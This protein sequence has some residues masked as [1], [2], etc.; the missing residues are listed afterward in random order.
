MMQLVSNIVTQALSGILEIKDRISVFSIWIPLSFLFVGLSLSHED[1][2]LA[3][4]F[5][6]NSTES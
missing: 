3:V 5:L 2:T 4:G 6:K 1:K